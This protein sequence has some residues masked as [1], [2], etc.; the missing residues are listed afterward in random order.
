MTRTFVVSLLAL[1]ISLVSVQQEIEIGKEVNAQVRKEVPELRDEQAAAYVRSIGQRLV[2]QAPGPQYPYSFTMADY[3]EINAFALPGGP[4]WINRG[5]LHTATNESQ[6]AGVLAHEVAHIA[7]RHAADQLTKATVANLGL[8]LLGAILGNGGGAGAAQMA[9]SLLTNG[10]FLK[11]SRDD[12]RDADQV[13]LQI[14]RKAGWD[15]RGMVELFQILQQEAK[16]NPGSVETF[17]SSHPSPQDRI[18]RLQG[19]AGSGGTRDSQQF[20]SM[21]AR[22][23][24]MPAPKSMPRD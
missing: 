23:V 18:G 20:Q 19:L 14:L 13:G 10:I 1:Q 15:G 3:R 9:A 2:R 16:R 11:F 4:V 6:V 21:K 5:V 8:G 7:Q 17:F 22:L 12:E 24:R